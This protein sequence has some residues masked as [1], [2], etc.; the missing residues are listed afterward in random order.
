MCLSLSRFF[1][2]DQCET[3][4]KSQKKVVL[5]P[6]ASR[7]NVTVS[8]PHRAM[9]VPPKND[10]YE[11]NYKQPTNQVTTIRRF[12]MSIQTRGNIIQ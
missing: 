4:S 11:Y 10:T 7:K 2:L 12:K 6:K 8:Q 1:M 5:N 9:A 3:F